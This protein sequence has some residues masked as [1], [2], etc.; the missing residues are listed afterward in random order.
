MI[1]LEKME[2]SAELV[3]CAD[4]AQFATPAVQR[5]RGPQPELLPTPLADVEYEFRRCGPISLG[6]HLIL[7][8]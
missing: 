2:V 5:C 8:L 6:F 4:C 3:I 1:G 7:A